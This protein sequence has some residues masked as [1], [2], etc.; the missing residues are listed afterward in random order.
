MGLVISARRGQVVVVT[1]PSV[2]VQITA[3]TM[4]DWPGSAVMNAIITRC[5]VSQ[6]GNFQ[7]LHTLG[8]Y[9]YVYVFGDRMG[10]MGISGLAFQ[11]LI[12]SPGFCN[13]GGQG[14]SQILAFYNANRIANRPTPVKLTLGTGPT[15]QGFL[16][17]GSADLSEPYDLIW[18]FD[19][20]FSLIPPQS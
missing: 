2:P 9:I 18:Q 4:P 7:F 16:T 1:D 20:Q 19:F 10:Q 3:I 17:Q 8:N 5:V 6:Q 13:G 12:T 15:L 14:V 11:N